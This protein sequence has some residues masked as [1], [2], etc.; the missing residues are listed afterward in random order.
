MKRHTSYASLVALGH[1]LHH[2]DVFAPWRE[3][4]QLGGKT[5]LHEPHQKVLD[6][7]VS[8]LA[9][10][11]SLKQINT[12]LRPDTALAAAWG[13]S[14]FADQ[15]MITRVLDAFTPLMGAQRRTASAWLYIREGQALHHPS[16]Q[17]LLFVDI[18]LTGLPAGRRAEAS[19]KDDF[20]GGKT[21]VGANWP[22]SVPRNTMKAWCPSHP[23]MLRPAC[24]GDASGLSSQ[25]HCCQRC[26][27]EFETPNARS[28]SDNHH[29][30]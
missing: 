9:D 24:S 4:V 16:E 26:S 12:R 14:G 1:L 30:Y 27:V 11:A 5:I 13:R 23:P 20:R 3:H 15:A 28:K 19:P 25:P 21:A 10:C 22:A 18:D 2:H 17:A 8:V 7:L 6:V 29:S